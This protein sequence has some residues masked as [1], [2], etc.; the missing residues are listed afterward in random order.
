[1]DRLTELYNKIYEQEKLI[2]YLI[3][4][5][6]EWIN[7]Y[8]ALLKRKSSRGVRDTE[9]MYCKYCNIAI[10]AGAVSY[11]AEGNHLT[12]KSHIKNVK[13]YD[14]PRYK[15][16]LEAREAEYNR[17]KKNIASAHIDPSNA[18]ESI[19]V[20]FDETRVDDITSNIEFEKE[21]DGLF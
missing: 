14:S 19:I 6:N 8:D 11:Q 3:N 13:F 5:R 12:S 18:F 21:L 2:T 17:V 20:E 16:F 1:M 15:D 7:K 9:I 10:M 4:Q